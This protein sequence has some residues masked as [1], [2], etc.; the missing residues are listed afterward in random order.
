MNDS[1]QDNLRHAVSLHNEGH[2]HQAA[3]KYSKL[4]KARPKD[5]DLLHL[6]GVTEIQ[7]GRAQC[8]LDRINESL[9]INPSQPAALSNQGNAL[10]ALN[11]PA[12]ALA[13]Y[14]RALLLSPDFLL[15]IYGRG[16]A[17]S[18]LGQPAKALADFDRAIELNPSFMQALLARGGVLLKLDR[19]ADSLE[20]H[21]RA[22]ALSPQFAQAHVGRASALLGLKAYTDALQSV[23]RA[24]HLDPNNAAALVVQGHVYSE[25]RHASAA[26]DAYDQALGLDPNLPAAWFSKGLALSTLARFAEAVT[27]VRRA[28]ELNPSHAYAPGVLLHAQLQVCDWQGYAEQVRHIQAM[29]ERGE[30]ADF[31]FSYLAVSDS[32]SLQ[33]R[34]ARRF[35]DLQSSQ[36]TLTTGTLP[37]VHER[38]RVAYISGDFLEHPISYLM[39]GV[40]EKHDRRLFEVIGISLREDPSSPTGQRV[41]AAFE[42]YVA[43]ESLSDEALAH[44]IKDMDVDIA[45]DLMGY[46]GEHRT[47]VFTHRPAPIQVNY[48]GYPA[49]MGCGHM[50]YIVADEFL[51]PSALRSHYSESIAYLPECFQA[52]DDRRPSS[53]E[54]PTRAQVGL[55][56]AG[57]V[58]CSFHSSYKINPPIFDVWA[59][60][61]LGNP[62]SVLWLL[63]GNPVVEQNLRRE[64]IARGLEPDR[65]VF[66][67]SLPYPQ[68]LARLQL[69]DLYLDTLPFNGGTT[70]SDALWAGVP[71]LTCAGECFAARMSGSLLHAV[72]LPEL[73]THTLPD[74][75][76]LACELARS[77]RQLAELRAVL[78]QRKLSSPL[79]DTDRF[80]RHLEAAYLIMNE[81]RRDGLSPATFR[82]APL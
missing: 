17:L 76:R 36:R 16:N 43:P 6:L 3:L 20:A 82:V 33:L 7:L 9:A 19:F 77:P 37:V 70:T 18:A 69:A 35:A 38:V 78:A 54:F 64:A 23:N 13:S 42:R 50:D 40:F 5:P 56:T 58:W 75:E 48:L 22:I 29:I 31:P 53:D 41:K 26:I 12:E 2:A 61:L 34:C 39:A 1:F 4:L 81:R 8:G 27:C 46:T 57:F 71:V 25:L 10:L 65:L 24:R 32:P 28:L 63:G 60:L 52:N 21:D 59:R 14:H 51:I 11:R 79:F 47:G 15:A 68:H 72:G 45:V 67:A 55:P 62:D 74:Y 44:L 73:V 66:A 30:P 49:T 80:R